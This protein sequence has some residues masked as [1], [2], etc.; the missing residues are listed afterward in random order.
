MP[1]FYKCCILF[2]YSLYTVYI[3]KILLIYFVKLGKKK[4]SR[5]KA[6]IFYLSYIFFIRLLF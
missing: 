5:G 6:Y 3:L 4:V 2:M 1:T